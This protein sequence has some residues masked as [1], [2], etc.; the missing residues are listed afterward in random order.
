MTLSSFTVF[1]IR[2]TLQLDICSLTYALGTWIGL[3]QS[4]P[5]L[6]RALEPAPH[7]GPLR[8]RHASWS[9]HLLAVAEP[10][11]LAVILSQEAAY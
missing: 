6:R 1:F 5:T 4:L 2:V 9:G 3:I 8:T 7:P 10:L 11:F